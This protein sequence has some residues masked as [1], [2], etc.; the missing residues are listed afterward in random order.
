[1]GRKTLRPQVLKPIA[2]QFYHQI[3]AD[4]KEAIVEA[5]S[6]DGQ[7]TGSSDQT[8]L[9]TMAMCMAGWCSSRLLAQAEGSPEVA[10]L[11][12]GKAGEWWKV[13]DAGLQSVD[14]D[15]KWCK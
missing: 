11:A 6:I 15:Q 4:L 9:D 10:V 5:Y 12:V 1:M 3:S 7:L 13:V 2:T 14:D 8:A